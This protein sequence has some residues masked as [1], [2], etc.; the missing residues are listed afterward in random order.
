MASSKVRLFADDTIIYYTT[1]N[2]DQLQKDLEKL[3]AWEKLWDIEFHPAKCEHITFTQKRTT[4]YKLHWETIQ[5]YIPGLIKI[6][7]FYKEIV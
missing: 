6:T 2:R 5:K 1:A 4:D 3:E 7:V